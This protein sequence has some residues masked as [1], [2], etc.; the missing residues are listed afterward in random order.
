MF[1]FSMEP[2]SGRVRGL[3]PQW[4]GMPP[5]LPPPFAP[6]LGWV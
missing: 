5:S 6:T 3:K 1:Y 4:V 2:K